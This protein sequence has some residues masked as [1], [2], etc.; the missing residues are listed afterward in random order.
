[1]CIVLINC[2]GIIYSWLLIV[3]ANSSDLLFCICSSNY[4]RLIRVFA[5]LASKALILIKDTML[6]GNFG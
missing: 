5:E 6:T 2:D 1:M 3:L 4:F